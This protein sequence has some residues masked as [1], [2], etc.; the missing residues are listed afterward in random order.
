[1]RSTL[2]LDG[3]HTEDGDVYEITDRHV[4][5]MRFKI[6]RILSSK[7][8]VYRYMFLRPDDLQTYLEGPLGV[9]WCHDWEI[10]L[11][12]LTGWDTSPKDAEMYR[13][14]ATIRPAHVDMARTV[15]QN[16]A[17]PWENEI[18]MRAGVPIMLQSVGLLPNFEEN[19]TP[20]EQKFPPRQY[21]A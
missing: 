2:K 18:T 16:L 21:R 17:V 6:E 13:L 10:N 1:M 7:P 9:F 3:G 15:L 19:A 14:T 11:D 5:D 20:I 8:T 12:S 4:R